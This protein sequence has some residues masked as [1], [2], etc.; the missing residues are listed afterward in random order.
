[1]L[2]HRFLGAWASMAS[3]SSSPSASPPPLYDLL[4][5][6]SVEVQSPFK[7]SQRHLGRETPHVRQVFHLLHENI[8]LLI[9][10]NER[11]RP[12]LLEV[13]VPLLL[14]RPAI[15]TPLRLAP[16]KACQDLRPPKTYGN[17]PLLLEKPFKTPQHPATHGVD[18]ASA[19]C[20]RP[21]GRPRPCARW[22]R[23]SGGSAPSLPAP[24]RAPRG[25]RART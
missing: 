10:L 21:P 12:C 8:L 15:Q 5:P 22:S 6:A 7:R 13:E 2:W 14:L 20:A 4:D 3:C 11:K 24:A 25:P 23:S 17:P 18:G 9:P 16:F 19:P 1:M